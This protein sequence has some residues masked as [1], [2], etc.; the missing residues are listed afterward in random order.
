M[1]SSLSRY[2]VKLE[3]N[4]RGRENL[5]P[6]PKEIETEIAEMQN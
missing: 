1:D 3:G 5:Y 2:S 4:E 6:L